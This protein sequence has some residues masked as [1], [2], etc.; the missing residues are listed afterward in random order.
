[1]QEKIV[2][3]VVKNEAPFLLE[4][5]AFQK[6]IGFDRVVIYTNGCTDLTDPLCAAL[7]EQ[8]VIEHRICAQA[9][10]SPQ[11]HASWLFRKSE[12]VKPGDWLMFCDPDEFLNI[13]FGEGRVDDLIARIAGYRGIMVP[14]RLFGDSGHLQYR[15]RSVSV[16]YQLAA[17]P[18]HPD[19]R[20]VKSF[21][22]YGSDVLAIGVHVPEMAASFWEGGPSFASSRLTAIDP[23]L[24]AYSAWREVGQH[25]TCD[26]SDS[27]Y[28]HVQMNHYFVRSVA[29]Y[30]IKYDRG[31]GGVK[32]EEI[33]QKQRQYYGGNKFEAAN[34]NYV[35]DS[36]ILRHLPQLDRKLAELL[37]IPAVNE[38]QARIVAEFQA[39][40]AE[41]LKRNPT[42]SPPEGDLPA[43]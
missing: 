41:F 13:K 35:Q 8:G 39:F 32:P 26:S 9:T 14:W 7:A 12:G 27:T 33:L 22:E 18:T 30:A 19:R 42:W 38:I 1:M 24:A 25:A 6:V 43:A 28:E 17:L 29:C 16:D 2:F 34:T 5:I 15:G 31:P 10:G 37:A 20:V 40:E 11:G 4:W 23:T 36:S 3:T 21:Y